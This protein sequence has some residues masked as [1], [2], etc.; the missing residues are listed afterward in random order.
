MKKKKKMLFGF[1]K[2]KNSLK[3]IKN[4]P[5]SLIKK[6]ELPQPKDT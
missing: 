5:I 3:I 2:N 1:L 6:K 4:K